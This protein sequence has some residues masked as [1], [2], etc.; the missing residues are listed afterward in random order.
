MENE[1][2]SL[3][4][5]GFL[6]GLRSG[7]VH[8]FSLKSLIEIDRLHELSLRWR[9][10]KPLPV[11]HGPIKDEDFQHGSASMATSLFPFLF[12]GLIGLN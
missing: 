3:R 1:H 7:L 4:G 10:L 12:L 9:L 5:G 11:R 8:E 6:S 2:L